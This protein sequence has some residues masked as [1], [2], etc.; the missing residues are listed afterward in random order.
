M[1]AGG[2]P[3]DYKPEYCQMVIDHM[4]EGLS[5]ESFAGAIG[6]SKQTLYDWAERNKEFLDA[7]KT[8]FEKSRLFWEKVGINIA[9]TGEGNATAFI[10][11]MKNRFSEDWSDKTK[12]DVNVSGEGIKVVINERENGTDRSD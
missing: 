9:K 5:F 12:S 4:A 2:R 1:S 11:N 6:V 10:F 7:K 8:A 3:T